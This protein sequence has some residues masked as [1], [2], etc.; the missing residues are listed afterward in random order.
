MNVQGQ[1]LSSTLTCTHESQGAASSLFKLSSTEGHSAHKDV[2]HVRG[3]HCVTCF[4]STS[5]CYCLSHLVALPTEKAR[6]R[7]FSKCL[8][9]FPGAAGPETAL[10]REEEKLSLSR[11]TSPFRSGQH[12]GS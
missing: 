2:E 6:G 7:I 5:I 1:P 9:E 8:A 11:G 10:V 4:S 12:Q 3:R